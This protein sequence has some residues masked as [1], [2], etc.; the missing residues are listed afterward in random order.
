MT[1]ATAASSS[2]EGVVVIQSEHD[3]GYISTNQRAEASLAMTI[4]TVVQQMSKQ[5]QHSNDMHHI[6]SMLRL[7]M[8]TRFSED[9]THTIQVYIYRKTGPVHLHLPNQTKSLFNQQHISTVAGS[10]SQRLVYLLFKCCNKF[11]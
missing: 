9:I 4:S 8:N 3:S 7:I 2:Q 1:Q 11:I 6:A 5:G 10:G